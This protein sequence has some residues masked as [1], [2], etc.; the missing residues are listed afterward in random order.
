MHQRIPEHQRVS[1]R[2]ATFLFLKCALIIFVVNALGAYFM[3]G[4]TF[5]D[6]L[7]TSASLGFFF[8]LYLYL[9]GFPRD[10]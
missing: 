1:K 10:Q 2:R 5:G 7:L 8:V 9:F 3:R 6:A 4:F